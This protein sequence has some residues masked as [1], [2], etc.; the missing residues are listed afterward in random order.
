MFLCAA[1]AP[2]ALGADDPQPKKT[3]KSKPAPAKPTDDGTTVAIDRAAQSEAPT[4]HSATEVQIDAKV[5]P[6]KRAA[7]FLDDDGGGDVAPAA[8]KSNVD[9]FLSQEKP[10]KQSKKNLNAATGVAAET[11]TEAKMPTSKA[12]KETSD[13]TATNPKKPKPKLK[14]PGAATTSEPPISTAP[15]KRKRGPTTVDVHAEKIK[16]LLGQ[17]DELPKHNKKAANGSSVGLSTGGVNGSSRKAGEKSV[18]IG[19]ARAEPAS[20]QVGAQQATQD[21]LEDEES[22]GEELDQAD[23]LLE[24][25][26]SDTEDLAQDEGF[27]KDKPV[28]ALPN[29]K[30]TQK[31]L[32]QAGQ[33]DNKDGPGTVYVGRIPHGFYET[34]MRQY[35]SQFGTI[36]KL[37][38][39][40]NRKTGHSKHFAFLEFQSNEVAKIVAETMDNYLMYGHILK[41][42]HVPQESLHPDTFKGANKRFRIAP[43]NRME[44]RALEA[45]KSESQWTKKNEKEQARREKKAEKLKAMGYEIE[46]PKLKSPT[47]VLQRKGLQIAEDEKGRAASEADEKEVPAP[48]VVPKDEIEI[49]KKSNK[50]KKGKAVVAETNGAID[51]DQTST[52]NAPVPSENGAEKGS[53]N[54]D[55]RKEKQKKGKG[56]VKQ[57][58]APLVTDEIS[59]SVNGQSSKTPAEAMTAKPDSAESSQP[60]KSK[61]KKKKVNDEKQ[62]V[63]ADATPVPAPAP[64][65]PESQLVE[66]AAPQSTAR[67]ESGKDGK[68]QKNKKR[69]S[70]GG[71]DELGELKVTSEPRTKSTSKKAKK[72]KK[73]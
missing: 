7:D 65:N 11:A 39:S 21:A 49:K 41:C 73:A 44:K 63:A 20:P 50:E 23:A 48:P 24:G 33:K 16:R 62:Q 34:E 69:K 54:Q 31:K 36:T 60:S 22:S 28:G 29:Y 18:E 15:I 38:L 40:R 43:H 17:K 4:T 32:R 14:S 2:V 68:S 58:A 70:S 9:N 26:D 46:L 30:K 35:F 6:R 67:V 8:R 13:K 45:P 10:K 61:M 56:E 12:M 55:K 1:A 59:T 52:A 66:E 71:D 42:K 47:D 64:A 51:Q 3:K 27:D 37:R 72:A 5:K 57:I 53:E 19:K 25:L